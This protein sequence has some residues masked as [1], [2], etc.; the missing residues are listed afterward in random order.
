MTESLRARYAEQL[1]EIDRLVDEELACW[2]WQDV[3]EMEQLVRGQLSRRGK[4][5]RPLL[6][7]T[8]A[9]LL[10]GDPWRVVP[11]A[12]G[13]ELYHLA[14]LILDDVQDNSA[15][16]RGMPAVHTTSGVSTA[17]N[18]AGLIRALSFQPLH[19]STTL[20]PLEKLRIHERVGTATMHLYLGQTIDIGWHDGWYS[21]INDYPYGQMTAWKTG[22]MFGCA[23]WIAAFVSGAP[24]TLVRSADQFGTKAGALYQLVD[25]YLDIFGPDGALLR[26]ALEDL[27]G[28]KPTWPLITLCR[29]LA[30]QGERGT[31]DLVVQRLCAAD[32]QEAD[33]NW[34]LEL[35]GDLGIAEILRKE[36]DW[37]AQQLALQAQDLASGHGGS[38]A[39][40]ELLIAILLR[41]ATSVTSACGG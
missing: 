25:D 41:S 10:G 23:A 20:E 35:A 11:G 30:A 33:W 38:T 40:I 9:D 34:L 37:R 4:R 16:R 1:F 15:V 28:G 14:S 39:E 3:P 7:F 26:P 13:V 27:R 19:R 18:A 31:A 21:T 36:L 2:P 6:M 32:A 12:T 17:L 24:E 8:L 5:L 29:V 22:A